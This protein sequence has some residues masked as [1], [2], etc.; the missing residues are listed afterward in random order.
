MTACA[1][2]GSLCGSRYDFFSAHM[3]IDEFL[4][5]IVKEG[6]VDLCLPEPGVARMLDQ[7]QGQGVKSSVVTARGYLPHAQAATQA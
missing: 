1:T 3:D 4:A 7:L 6:V 2:C 5:R